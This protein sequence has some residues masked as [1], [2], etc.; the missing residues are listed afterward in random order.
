MTGDALLANRLL[1]T[2]IGL[3]LPYATRSLLVA[4][5]GDERLSIFGCAAFWCRSLSIGFLPFL[6][7]DLDPFAASPPGPK[8]ERAERLTEPGGAPWTLFEKAPGSGFVNVGALDPGPCG[9]R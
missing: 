6:R 2:A 4:L 3:A 1:L 8:W 7:G 9:S 5:R